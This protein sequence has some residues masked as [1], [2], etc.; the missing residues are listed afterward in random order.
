MIQQMINQ[1]QEKAETTR[2][3]SLLG[4]SRSGV[5]AARHRRQR[6]RTRVLSKPLQAAFQASGG[7][8]GSRRLSATLK[9]QGLPAG[10]H[11][12]RRLMRQM[13][14]KARR[15]AKAGPF[16][17]PP[18]LNQFSHTK[19]GTRLNS[20]RLSVTSTSSRATAWAAISM[21]SEPMGLPLRS[22]AA[23]MCA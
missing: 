7:N 18:H 23:R 21:S 19:P 3:C 14:L 9:A 13:G 11:R 8:Y 5:Y 17:V 6:P 1:W 2:L 12:V 20:R 16:M 22:S 15:R 10:R 4:V